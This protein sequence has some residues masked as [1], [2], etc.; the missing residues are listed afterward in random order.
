[1]TTRTDLD[2]LFGSVNIDKWADLNNNE[3]SPEIAARVAWA[4][5]LA[6]AQVEAKF[7]ISTY[8]YSEVASDLLVINA[9]AIKAGLLLYANRGVSD[10]EG[11]QENPMWRYYRREYDQFFKELY[12]G[13]LALEATRSCRPFPAVVTDNDG[14]ITTP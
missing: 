6:A 10:E 9:E 13:Q 8:A 14:D 12:A 11:A 4:V 7:R 2:N 1:M 5:A 3:S